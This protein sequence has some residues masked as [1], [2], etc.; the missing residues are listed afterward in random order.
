MNEKIVNALRENITAV[1]AVQIAEVMADRKIDFVAKVKLV[2]SL[3][4]M[5]VALV[6]GMDIMVA[7]INNEQDELEGIR[8]QINDL[9]SSDHV[10]NKLEDNDE[11]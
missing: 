5:A 8:D 4:A 9:L 3:A 2:D 1:F 10:N 11:S 6:E 7:K